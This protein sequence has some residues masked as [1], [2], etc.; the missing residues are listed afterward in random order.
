MLADVTLEHVLLLGK[1]RLLLETG[2]EAGAE[3]IWLQSYLTPCLGRSVAVLWL[4]LSKS[5]SV[6]WQVAKPDGSQK[7]I[8]EALML[9]ENLN[10]FNLP[11]HSTR[12]RFGNCV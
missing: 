1:L 5:D 6:K 2:T 12:K 8:F 3:F 7:G 4:C 11:L 9:E 10:T